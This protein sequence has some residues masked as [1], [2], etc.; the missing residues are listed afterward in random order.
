MHEHIPAMSEQSPAAGLRLYQTRFEPS[1]W[2]NILPE[3]T[4]KAQMPQ[5]CSGADRWLVLSLVSA[6]SPCHVQNCCPAGPP[7][8]CAE[9]S[10]VPGTGFGAPQYKKDIKLQ[11]SIWRRAM[12][13]FMGLEGK[14]YEEEL[15]S[16][17]LFSPEH[18][19][20]RKGLI[21]GLSSKAAALSSIIL[22]WISVLM[23]ILNTLTSK[24]Y[25]VYH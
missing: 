17:G 24:H 13:M 16:P 21:F 7:S 25:Y 11:Q 3:R 1:E 8:I 15:R 2:Q 4:R 9:D 14:M 10:V 12:K 22:P 18:K 23:T 6:S 20:L 5:L 19:R